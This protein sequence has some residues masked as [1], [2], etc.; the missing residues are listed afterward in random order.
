MSDIPYPLLPP[1]MSYLLI[2][3][4][5]SSHTALAASELGI[6]GTWTLM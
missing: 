6:E 2:V 1:F 3:K 4:E 5:V